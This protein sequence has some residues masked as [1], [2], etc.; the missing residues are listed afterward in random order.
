MQIQQNQVDPDSDGQTTSQ[1]RRLLKQVDAAKKPESTAEAK[2]PKVK[3][4]ADEI[5]SDINRA[6]PYAIINLDRSTDQGEGSHWIGVAHTSQGLLVYDSFGKMHD[7]PPE[8]LHL[9]GKATVTNPDAEQSISETNCGAR[10]LA[11]LMV[12]DLFGAKEAALV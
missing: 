12:V 1:R 7:T 3:A 10:V 9:Y 4:K 5:P 11:W 8:L 2:T 6:R